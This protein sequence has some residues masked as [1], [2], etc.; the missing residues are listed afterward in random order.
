MKILRSFI[1][2]YFDHP[3]G[4]NG[5]VDP[6]YQ[7]SQQPMWSVISYSKARVKFY[8]ASRPGKRW[9]KW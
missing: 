5:Y 8:W 2:N 9:K 4:P 7:V 1:E 6:L 3:S